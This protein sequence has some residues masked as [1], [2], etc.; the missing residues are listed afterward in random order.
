[1]IDKLKHFTVKENGIEVEYP[2]AFD[3][4]VLEELQDKYGSVDEVKNILEPSDGKEVKLKDLKFVF[5]I[6]I[7]EGI[8]IENE[9]KNTDRKFIT[10]KK[11]GRLLTEAGIKNMSN[12]L[13]DVIITSNNSNEE[14]N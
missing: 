8:D 3:I 14:K 7:N 13:K 6:M 12:Q 5:L 1:M 10:D 4:N 9:E 2:V 11:V